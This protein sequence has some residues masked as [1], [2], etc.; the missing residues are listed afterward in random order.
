[1]TVTLEALSASY[2]RRKIALSFSWQVEETLLRSLL[3]KESQGL[4]QRVERADTATRDWLLVDAVSI[5]VGRPHATDW[6]RVRNPALPRLQPAAASACHDAANLCRPDYTVVLGLERAAGAAPR[7][8]LPVLGIF[9]VRNLERCASELIHRPP[10]PDPGP[11]ARPKPPLLPR[12]SQHCQS[13]LL[14][15]SARQSILAT[16]SRHNIHRLVRTVERHQF[17]LS[18]HSERAERRATPRRR[19]DRKKKRVG[20]ADD[21]FQSPSPL[22]SPPE[23]SPTRAPRNDIYTPEDLQQPTSSLMATAIH[24]AMTMTPSFNNTNQCLDPDTDSFF[25]FS[26]LPSPT[27]S[28]TSRQPS[29]AASTIASPTNTALDGEELQTPAK[30]SHEYERFK[31]QTGLPT[32]SIAGLNRPVSG[33]Y[34]MFSSSGLD[35]VSLM[36][37]SSMLDAGWNNGLGMGSDVNMNLDLSFSQPAFF[38]PAN[39]ASQP[40]SDDFIDPSAITQE[41]VTTIRAW[42]GMHQQQ[43]ALAKAQ[44]QA[45]QQRQQQ[46][47]QQQQQKQAAQQQQNRVHPNR[48]SGSSQI[49]DARTEETIA[50]VVNQIRQNSQNSALSSQ[51]ENSQNLLPH[52]VR[53]KKDEEDM[54][55][56]ERLLASEEGKK[57]SSKERRQLRNKVSA[58]AFRSRRKEYI[59]QLEGEVAMKT[60]ECNE[61]RSQNRA[62]MEENARSRAFIER[63]LRHQAFTPFLEELSRDESLQSKPVPSLSTAPTPTPASTRKDVNPYQ[64]QFAI[65][66]PENPQI[67][68]ALIPETPLDISMLNLN[69]NTN[70]N[71]WPMNNMSFNYQQPQV[72]AVLEVPQGPENPID[73]EALS[74]KGFQA[75]A[76]EESP[77]EKVKPDYPVLSHPVEAKP[78]STEPQQEGDDEDDDPEFDLYRSS[79]AVAYTNIPPP[80]AEP[81]NHE[82]LFGDAAPEKVFAHFE[83]IV[84]DERSEEEGQRL[85]ARFELNESKQYIIVFRSDAP[86][87]LGPTVDPE[88]SLPITVPTLSARERN[89]ERGYRIPSLHPQSHINC[90]SPVHQR[91]CLVAY[92]SSLFLCDSQVPLACDPEGAE[93]GGSEHEARRQ[94][95]SETSGCC[96][97]AVRGSGMRTE[98]RGIQKKISHIE[99]GEVD[100]ATL[101]MPSPGGERWEGLGKAM[102]GAQNGNNSEPL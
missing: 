43:A 69:T 47:A 45:Q 91:I 12:P 20:R 14:L 19:I 9:G 55:E 64:N 24:P 99:I 87:C 44:A 23:P 6:A 76:D 1:M 60:N 41:E 32:G 88:T 96:R 79:P 8:C 29:N 67:G 102:S 46:I 85:M 36:G 37:D 81:E 61:L 18:H 33:G 35:E 13:S 93:L 86:N 53:M 92:L 89:A 72:F 28:S 26:Q 5:G 30:P 27:P 3:V 39:D 21:D 56:D 4:P 2:A 59:G 73:T 49:T 16:L 54:D 77:I 101:T 65:S 63:L 22:R 51:N 98:T 82:S 40:Q 7:P 34:S 11:D 50:R 70:G 15:S 68:M 97:L 25:D 10:P 42:P 71:N 94:G 78:A 74:G 52:I 100:R 80:S 84:S 66:Q 57:L 58:R 17:S 90:L 31:Q 38:Y 95:S 62:L 83:L 48:R 75:F